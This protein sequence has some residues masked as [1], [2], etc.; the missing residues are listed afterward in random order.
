MEA[1]ADRGEVTRQIWAFEGAGGGRNLS[2]TEPSTPPYP[3][4]ALLR[5]AGRE[6]LR[7]LGGPFERRNAGGVAAERRD[8][9]TRPNL[10]G[11]GEAKGLAR[12]ERMG[13]TPP[14]PT[15]PEVP[16]EDVAAMGGGEEVRLLRV[17]ADARTA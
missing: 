4:D 15:H 16:N 17:E 2:W 13:H 14:P 11:G 8:G 12:R 10:R 9:E 5:A 3:D 6:L 7:A 1:K